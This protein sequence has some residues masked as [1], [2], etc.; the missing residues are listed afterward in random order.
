MDT[1]EL[2][3][4]DPLHFR[5]I[6]VNGGVF[7]PLFPIVHNQ[8]LCLAHI[9]GEVVALAPHCL[10]SDLLPIGW[11]IV[12]GDQ[13]YHCC[14]VSKLNDDLGVVLGHAVVGEQGVQ[15]GTKHA[16]LTG[17]SVEDQH[18]ICVV[19]TIASWSTHALSTQPGNPSGPATL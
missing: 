4:L 2:E 14:V 9:E 5:P 19:K 10:V 1:K 3:T 12:G 6:D 8:L 17:L 18:D 15:E 13:A 7:G 11:L 16:P